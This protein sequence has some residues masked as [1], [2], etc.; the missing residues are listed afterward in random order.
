MGLPIDERPEAKRSFLAAFAKY[1]NITRAART[2]KIGR[3]TVYWWQEHDDAFLVAFRD[4]EKQAED[5]LEKTAWNEAVAGQKRVKKVYDRL[6]NL[7]SEE[8]WVERNALLM[9]F[10]LK[11][12]NPEK[13]RDNHKITIDYGSVPTDK[14]L[15]EAERLGLAP[16]GALPP[17]E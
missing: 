7:V 5:E 15:E 12:R 11:A 2:A 4:A 14:L 16:A 3:S 9:M 13:Y 10:L 1:G 8:T 6:G 17:P